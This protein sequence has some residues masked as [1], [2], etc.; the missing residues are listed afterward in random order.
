MTD[1]PDAKRPRL[2]RASGFSDGPPPPPPPEDAAESQAA[3]LAAMLFPSTTNQV[4]PPAPA[5]Y[6][7]PQL[8]GTAI[9]TMQAAQSS[10]EMPTEAGD[11]GQ[12]DFV[13]MPNNAVGWLK[14]KG[15]LMIQ[16]IEQRSGAKIE[17]DQAMKEI[18]YSVAKF[19]N[20]S[21]AQKKL[22]HGLVSAEV[23][24]VVDAAGGPIDDT[25]GKKCEYHL[26]AQ[27][28]GW[29][30]GPKGVVVQELQIIT[31]TRIDVNQRSAMAGMPPG[32][33][34]IKIFGTH[35]GVRLANQLI[36]AELTKLNQ[37]AALLFVADE[38]GGLEEADRV[39]KDIVA[40]CGPAFAARMP[41]GKGEGFGGGGG[42]GGMH[43]PPQQM[44]G[45]QGGCGNG[46]YGTQ[47]GGYMQQQNNFQQ[48]QQFAGG[49]QQMAQNGMPQQ[50]GMGQGYSGGQMGGPM[51]NGYS[52]MS[53]Q[54]FGMQQ[55]QQFQ[56]QGQ[57]YQPQ[58]H[59][60]SQNW[61]QQQ[62]VPSPPPAMQQNHSDW[63][64]MGQPGQGQGQGFGQQ[65]QANWNGPGQMAPHAKSAPFVPQ[66]QNSWA[67][68]G[69]PAQ[70]S[71]NAGGAGGPDQFGQG[72]WNGPA[73]SFSQQ[74]A[75]P[76]QGG[77]PMSHQQQPGG[78]SWGRTGPGSDQ[79][80]SQPAGMQSFQSPAQGNQWQ[81]SPAPNQMTSQWQGGQQSS[82]QW[83]PPQQQNQFDSQGQL[84]NQ[85]PAQWQ[86]NFQA[87]AQ[88]GTW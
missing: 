59:Q 50:M 30:K 83:Q 57:Q 14:G 20:A 61:A 8:A 45:G 51:Q 68:A 67:S 37:Q 26:E 66:G 62:S 55:Q 77:G 54:G 5:G 70:H 10:F 76:G 18:G 81:A 48:Q 3:S 6:A 72:A 85:S 28:V 69:Q 21:F 29:V 33:A 53:S 71:F 42:G 87:T 65:A 17:I 9:G 64:A 32:T 58:Q 23:C 11:E 73:Q 22:A 82:M 79:G 12:Y 16:D 4:Q 38:P 47:G 74:Q 86:P 19:S 36:A 44:H 75:F 2:E 41:R 60:Q 24:K 40:T 31:G 46:M 88:S 78:G 43:Q 25:I 35:E 7:A 34:L 39:W 63:N 49:C 84:P 80:F 52:Q 27:Y 13:K 56:Q 15:G 1:G